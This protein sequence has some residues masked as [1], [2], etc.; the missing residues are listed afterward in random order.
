VTGTT[1]KKKLINF[2]LKVNSAKDVSVMKCPNMEQPSGVALLKSGDLVITDTGNRAN[3]KIG[4]YTTGMTGRLSRLRDFG[5]RGDGEGEVLTANYVTVDHQ[6][7]V[8]ISDTDNHVVKV[9]YVS[10]L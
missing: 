3:K 9:S 1:N 2:V 6:D 10:D 5:A 8:I 4:V 7:R